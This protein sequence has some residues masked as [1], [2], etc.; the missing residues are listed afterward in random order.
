MDEKEQRISIGNRSHAWLEEMCGASRNDWKSSIITGIDRRAFI[1]GASLL[2]LSA[3]PVRPAQSFSGSILAAAPASKYSWPVRPLMQ[4]NLRHSLDAKCKTKQVEDSRIVDDMESD[5]GWISSPAV[6]LNYTDERPRAGKRSL[7]IIIEQRDENYIRSNRNAHGSFSGSAALFA[8]MPAAPVARLKLTPAQDWSNFNRISVWCYVHPC[9]NPVNSVCA[10]FLC[11]GAEAGPYDPVACHYFSDM[12]QGEWNL[13]AWE[14]PE[15]RRDRVVEVSLFIPATGLPFHNASSRLVLDFDQ[16]QVERVAAEQVE[17]WDISPNKLAFSHVG[18]P[19]H[20]RKQAFGQSGQASSFDLVDADSGRVAAS[21]PAS[22]IET[23]RGRYAVYD[24]SAFNRPGRYRIRAGGVQSEAFEI[25]IQAWRP[26]VEAALN[27]FYGLRCGFAVPGAHDACHCDVTARYKGETRIV[28]GGWHDA[29]N[30]AQDAN[31]TNLSVCALLDLSEALAPQD[32]ELSARALEE[33]RWGLEWIQRL[34]FGPGIRCLMGGYS[35]FTDNVPGTNDDVVNEYVGSNTFKNL[36]AALAEVRGAQLLRASDSLLAGELLRASEEDF[37][38]VLRDRPEPPVE[39]E[40]EPNWHVVSWQNEAGYMAL[41][42]VELYRATGKQTY[43]EDAARIGRWLLELQEFRFIEGS[44]I[45]GYFYEDA[46][47]T[48]ILHE[49]QRTSGAQNSFEEGA[50]LAYQALCEALPDHPDWIEWY[51]GLVVY[52]EYFCR[53]GSEA[54]APFNLVPSA[55]WR[56]SDLDAPFSSDMLAVRSTQA[57]ATPNALFPTPSTKELIRRQIGEMYEAG[58]YLSPTQRLRTFPLWVDHIRHGATTVHLTKTLGL[59]AAA[60]GRNNADLSDLVSRQL[61]WEVGANPFSRS[62]VYG[63]G[64]D[65]WQNFTVS[66]PNLVGGLSVGMNS[67]RN[68]SPA[69]GNNALFPY[70]EIWVLSSCRLAANL[71]RLPGTARVEGSAPKGAKFTHLGTKQ[72]TNLRRGNF[73]QA[74]PPGDYELTY[75]GFT[76]R[77]TLVDGR[78]YTLDLD[79][80]KAVDLDL[81]TDAATGNDVRLRITI[82]G[83][84]SRQVELRSSNAELSTKSLSVD[85]GRGGTKT[86]ELPLRIP[87][88]ERPWVVVAVPDKRVHE[89][90]EVFGTARPLPSLERDDKSAKA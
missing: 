89:A 2:A 76:R 48:R 46:A 22:D 56:R 62:L 84:G 82:R 12:K 42:A 18:Y 83:V 6:Q 71:A 65:W 75:G 36:T 9:G 74:L 28:G 13:L 66:L 41:T 16:L 64:Y 70:K 87:D 35:Y 53:K 14:I 29:A 55:V 25:R 69:W 8:H 50:L 47:R 26:L 33:A 60:Q 78:R 90:V 86:L 27:G 31:N 68:D 32:P 23:R 79:P 1:K 81:R 39:T 38:T 24:F 58:T 57:D 67:Y 77:I 30:L 20:G 72:I 85:L 63:V 10:Q 51:S 5:R 37:A 54:A 80:A 17:G 21:L 34:R 59:A 15:I 7:R 88:S 11:E 52:S 3:W 19:L 40:T 49:F 44:P 45:T 4:A 43:A 61:Q 73:T